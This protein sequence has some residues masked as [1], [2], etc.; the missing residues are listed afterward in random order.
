MNDLNAHE[1]GGFTLIEVLIAMS[2]LS[3][4]MGLLFF[5]MRTAFESWNIGEAKVEQINKKAVFYQFFK[6]HLTNS[7]PL[8]EYKLENENSTEIKKMVFQGT[9]EQIRFV[10]ALPAASIRKG[11]QIFNI[12]FNPQQTNS[13]IVSLT[14]YRQPQQT[15]EQTQLLD[16][17]KQIQF[18]YFGKFNE[19]FEREWQTDWLESEEL[20]RLVR[21]KVVLDDESIWPDMVFPLKVTAWHTASNS[22]PD[23]KSFDNTDDKK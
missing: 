2:L 22:Q 1:K 16:H 10:S 8:F 21:I 12:G 19:N 4:M 13:I 11:E 23:Y 5:S 9:S 20:P 18:S 17:V 15:G 14:P 7:K 3:I 6:Q